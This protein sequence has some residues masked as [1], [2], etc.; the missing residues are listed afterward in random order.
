MCPRASAGCTWRCSST[1]AR[2]ASSGGP[3]RAELALGALTMALRGRRPAPGLIHHTDRGCQYTATTYQARP[4]AQGLVCS[5][6][7]ASECLDNAM[8]ERFFATFKAAFADGRRWPTR[9]AARLAIFAW[10]EVW[11]NRQRR[12]SPLD[13]SCPSRGRRWWWC[14]QPSPS[15]NLSALARQPQHPGHAE[16][17]HLSTPAAPVHH[18]I[19]SILSAVEVHAYDV[20]GYTYHTFAL[21]PATADEWVMAGHGRSYNGG[22]AA[23]PCSRIPGR[24][25]THGAARAGALLH[26]RTGRGNEYVKDSTLK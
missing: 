14:V 20:V 5:M 19:F 10:I 6:S 21:C 16:A 25:P 23:Q 15:G 18:G 11:Y 7:R 4:A 17:G 9:A 8:A 1:L 12:H 3:C 2:A 24:S 26:R 22:L 13:I